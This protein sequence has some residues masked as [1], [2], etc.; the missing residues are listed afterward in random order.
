MRAWP[1]PP[2][3]NTFLR[4]RG[5]WLFSTDLWHYN[6][7]LGFVSDAGRVERF[8]PRAAHAAFIIETRLGT[9]LLGEDLFEGGTGG[10]LAV[11]QRGDDGAWSYE[12][13]AE[14]PSEAFGYAF[15]PDGTL[16]VRDPYGAVA[17]TV[18]LE[19]LPLDCADRPD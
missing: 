19:I 8:A 9:T 17:I 10:V 18:A 4:V 5:G 13:V 16:L 3:P 15:A 6:G 14:L 1:R 12:P 7:E 11:V 2:W